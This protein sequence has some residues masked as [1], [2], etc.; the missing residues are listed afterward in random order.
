MTNNLPLLN[1]TS[2]IRKPGVRSCPFGLPVAAGCRAA[3]NS[4]ESMVVL[5]D[6]D[7]D[8]REKQAKA[9]RRV[10]VFGQTGERCV[11]A[12]RIVEDKNIVHCDYGEGG[13]KIRDFAIRP[14]PLYPRLFNGVG[15]YGLYSYPMSGYSNNYGSGQAFTGIY[16]MY[17]DTGEINISKQSM[18]FNPS[19]EKLANNLSINQE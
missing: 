17:N 9:N 11:Y 18:E 6:I 12:D 2:V 15:S 19:L 4:V 1:K 16:A 3:G 13:E 8:L 10:Y 5:E 7:K 14:S